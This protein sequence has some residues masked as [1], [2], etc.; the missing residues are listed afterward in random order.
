MGFGEAAVITKISG[1][2]TI[3]CHVNGVRLAL[4]HAAA[5]RILVEPLPIRQ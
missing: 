1:R 2:E 4:S 3:L 5:S